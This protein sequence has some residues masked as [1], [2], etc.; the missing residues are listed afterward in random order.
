MEFYVLVSV[1]KSGETLRES[2]TPL[3]YT[4]DEKSGECAMPHLD[5]LFF[6]ADQVA[7]VTGGTRGHGG[8]IAE[9]CSG[10]VRG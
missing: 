2:E 7:V 9:G 3:P 4:A 1:G 6:L 5:Q 8:A 10:A